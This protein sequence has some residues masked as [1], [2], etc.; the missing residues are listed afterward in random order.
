MLAFLS[1]FLV[2]A[3]LASDKSEI[4]QMP[5]RAICHSVD[6]P[7][8]QFR[9]CCSDAGVECL[10]WTGEGYVPNADGP[11]YFC[12]YV[13]DIPVGGTAVE[14]GS[15]MLLLHAI[16]GYL[17]TKSFNLS[18]GLVSGIVLQGTDKLVLNCLLIGIFH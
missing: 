10:P 1:C 15:V 4:C 3:T 17:R 5:G 13:D 7:E 9:P 2:V 6:L 14:K 11:D 16:A 12:Q 18:L 8:H